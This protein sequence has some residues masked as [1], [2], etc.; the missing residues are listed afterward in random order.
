MKIVRMNTQQP[1]RLKTLLPAIAIVAMAF[2]LFGTGCSKQDPLA[3]Q[4]E[5]VRNG[6]PPEKPGSDE[7]DPISDQALRIRSEDFINFQEDKENKTT[8]T[9]ALLQ[10]VVGGDAVVGR[11]F[12][13]IVNNLNDLKGSTFDQMTGEFKWK[14]AK[15]FTREDYS[16]NTFISVTIATLASP[17]MTKTQ[18]IPIS[19]TRAVN[20]PVVQSITFDNTNPVREGE[21]AMFTVVV[22]DDSARNEDGK[23]PTILP[24][25]TNA[26]NT[27]G[28][29]LAT[30]VRQQFAVPVVDPNDSSLYTFKMA[31]DLRN[32]ELTKTSDSFNFS[33][34]AKNRYNEV[35]TSMS[36]SVTVLTSLRAP[37]TTLSDT[38][39]VIRGQ[40]NTINFSIYD[41]FQEADLQVNWDRCDLLGGGTSCSCVTSRSGGSAG[42]LNCTLSWKPLATQKLGYIEKKLVVTARTKVK[43]DN[44]FQESKFSVPME[45][46]EGTTPAPAPEVE[47]AP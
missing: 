45:V 12:E 11:D 2:S 7:V 33:I 44:L 29:A 37:M 38:V 26:T 30:L 14:P 41:P 9:G 27:A 28:N 47:A 16:V 3:G 40:E 6:V 25:A 8:I 10:S 31:L 42:V 1:K 43:N 46:I 17:I 20:I 23:R 13:L 34:Q 5:N 21:R 4:P 15:G 24:V 18:K 36:K 32:A 22:K 19:V 39:T 35:S